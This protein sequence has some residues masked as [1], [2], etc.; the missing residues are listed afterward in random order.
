MNTRAT[1]IRLGWTFPA[2]VIA[3]SVMA[4]SHAAELAR[5]AGIALAIVYDTS[6]SMM[7][8][9]LDGSGKRAPKY[10]IANRALSAIIDR[11]QVVATGTPAAPGRRL[12]SGLVVFGGPGATMAVPFA[13]FNADALR[14]W[15]KS[16][17]KPQGSTPLGEAVRVAGQAVLASP[18]TRKHVLV[19]TDGVN[20][21][22]PDPATVMATFTADAKRQHGGISFHFVAF[23]VDAGVFDR[24]KKLGAT[25]VGAANEKQLNA[26]LEFI[27]E[28][29][30]LLEAEEPP[31]A[32]DKKK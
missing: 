6:G 10:R 11:L 23:D 22:G 30:I 25:V 9:V 18:M 20:T 5:E 1:I 26:K 15:V 4:G 24:V 21:S 8:Q 16:F 12:Q 2:L 3:I 29:K 31:T 27:L 19:L 28:E 14:G 17:S 7:E 13:N 32:S